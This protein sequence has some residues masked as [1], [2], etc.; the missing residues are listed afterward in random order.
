MTVFNRENYAEFLDSCELALQG[1]LAWQI[2]TGN[3]QPP[4]E[5][6]VGTI[7]T[8]TRYEKQLRD[9]NTRRAS[10]IT[11]LSSSVTAVYRNKIKEFGQNS[12]VDLMWNK[13]AELDQT[14]DIIFVNSIR[15]KFTSK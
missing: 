1:A 10:T 7:A 11:I 15:A 13:I 8:S 9:Y 3:K 2:I 12:R 5:P 6:Q 4:D 14:R